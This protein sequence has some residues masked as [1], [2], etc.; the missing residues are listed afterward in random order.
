MSN[1]L[2]TTLSRER[3]REGYESGFWREETV[4]ALA[5]ERA[6]RNPG[7][8]ALREAGRRITIGDLV[9]AAD[10]LSAELRRAGLRRGERVAAWL[11]SRAE[12]AVALL[13]CSRDG[14]VLCPSLHRD[15]TVAEVAGLLTRMRASALIAQPGYGADADRH[16]IFAQA[17]AI[18]SLRLVCRLEKASEATPPWPENGATPAPPMADPDSVVYLAFTSGTTG[19]PKGV[20]HSD[21]TLLGNARA[22]VADWS[23][24]PDDVI[25]TLSPLSHN[26]GFGSMVIALLCGAEL[27]IHDLPRGRSLLDR[28]V[29]TNTSYL[30]GVPTHAIDL[31]HEM[32]AR[33]MKTLGRVRGFRVSGAAVPRVVVAGLIEHGVTPQS[34][35]GMTEASSHHYTLP[36]D[37]PERMVETS[38]RVCPGYEVRVFDRDNPERELPAGEVGQIGG[39]GASLMLGYFDEQGA[40]ESSFNATGWF[41][42]GDLGWVD[43]AGYIRITGR[44]KDVIIRGGH[45]IFPAKIETLAM[46]HPAVLRAA[47]LPVPDE[48]LGEKVCLAV[49]SRPGAVVDAEDILLHLDAAGLSKYDQPEYFLLVEEIPLTASGKILKRAVAARVEAGELQPRPVRLPARA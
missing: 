34:G 44:K 12:V 2:L 29:E 15:H 20:M 26:L 21:N 10:R 1:T 18:T 25:A 9:A 49:M 48:R 41:M 19:A 32:R 5:A 46:Q 35:Y 40:T 8:P 6:A 24:G 36:D 22:I 17:S 39:R 45:N 38:G 37:P 14:L 27:V 43:E 7:A 3:L 31:L 4:Y 28:L 30:V 33:G 42:T 11:P 16:D 13:A 47:A 23:L